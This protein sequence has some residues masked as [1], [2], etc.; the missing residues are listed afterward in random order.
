LLLE[1]PHSFPFSS[2]NPLLYSPPLPSLSLSLSLSLLPPPTLKT[3]PHLRITKNK[4]KHT[5]TNT[6]LPNK[7]TNT[8]NNKK[9]PKNKKTKQTTTTQTSKFYKTKAT[10][11][12]SHFLGKKR[13][14]ERD[15]KAP[16]AVKSSTGLTR[17][18]RIPRDWERRR[19]GLWRERERERER[20]KG[21]GKSAEHLRFFWR[22]TGALKNPKR[23][24]FTKVN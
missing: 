23:F 8:H 17:G 4:E 21:R 10:K 19:R 24:H 1:T 7:H 12:K 9:R 13:R 3:S 18:G 6:Y 20:E 15:G 5:T 2:Y 16:A 14:G 22:G 11:R